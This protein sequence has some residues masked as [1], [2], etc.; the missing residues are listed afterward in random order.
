L[1]LA[2]K[3]NEKQNEKQAKN[4]QKML[5]WAPLIFRWFKFYSWEHQR[6]HPYILLTSWSSLLLSLS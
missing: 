5:L 2:V 6:F 1:N 4:G 3:T